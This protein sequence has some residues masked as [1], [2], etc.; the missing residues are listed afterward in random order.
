MERKRVLVAD[1]HL[2]IYEAVE[3]ILRPAFE[4]VA[5]VSG[6]EELLRAASAH[7]PDLLV[8]DVFLPDGGGIEVVRSLHTVPERP[9]WQTV[10]LTTY[11]D[12]GLLEE[13]LN[14]GALGYVLKCRA[15]ED[16]PM[17]ARS[18]LEGRE[19]VS[20]AVVRPSRW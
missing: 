6:G 1:N 14:A 16:L 18:V 17:A 2:R 8:V 11:Y 15:G 7:E 5:C 20:P 10:V 4:I 3:R 19:F 9:R 12:L 13:V